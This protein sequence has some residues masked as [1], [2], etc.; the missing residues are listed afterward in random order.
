[1]NG[2][3][4]YS[5]MHI[6]EWDTGVTLCGLDPSRGHWDAIAK[7]ISITPEEVARTP[8]LWCRK[9]W[10][11]FKKRYPMLVEKASKLTWSQ[12]LS[13]RMEI[14]FQHHCFGPIV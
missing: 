6:I 3:L 12:T 4:R 11:V 14:F 2:K 13:K 7:D 5:L 9:C 10:K 8:H 1:M